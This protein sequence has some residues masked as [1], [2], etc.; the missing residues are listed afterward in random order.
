MLL[1]LH[2]VMYYLERRYRVCARKAVCYLDAAYQMTKIDI[3]KWHVVGCKAPGVIQLTLD[4]WSLQ[5]NHCKLI[6][7]NVHYIWGGVGPVVM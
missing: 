4:Q 3:G 6:V 7:V 1:L 5:Q 2:L